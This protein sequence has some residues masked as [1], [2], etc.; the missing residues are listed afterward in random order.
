MCSIHILFIGNEL[1]IEQNKSRKKT[2][3]QS[4]STR[5][6]KIRQQQQQQITKW[7]HNHC[8]CVH[9][10]IITTRQDNGKKML[11][12]KKNLGNFDIKSIDILCVCV[13]GKI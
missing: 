5:Q 2:I 8:V 12:T 6:K 10:A 7:P 9:L 11:K 3:H 13:S 4:R 1:K